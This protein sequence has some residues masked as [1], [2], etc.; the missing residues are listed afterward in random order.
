MSSS[1]FCESTDI[2]TSRDGRNLR[3]EVHR[4]QRRRHIIDAAIEVVEAAPQGA[5][6]TL[7]DVAER[8]SLVRT[9]VQRHFGGRDGLLR[10]VQADVLDQAFSLIRGPIGETATFREV[11]SGWVGETVTWVRDHPNLHVLV[12]REVG[13]GDP[14]ELS[15]AIDSYADFLVGAQGVVIAALGLELDDR[16]LEETRLL[17]TG[18]IGQVRATVGHWAQRNPQ[19]VSADELRDLLT[20]WIEAQ[21]TSHVTT[22]GV[23]I[24]PTAA[25]GAL[26]NDARTR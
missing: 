12:E 1:A 6:M 25:W 9:V 23:E 21:L 5:E 18:V 19:V 7:Q 8:A 3:W 26:I 13:D 17:F 16:K 15:K 10:A 24:S 11:I 4:E 20:N 14:S 2:G 22:M